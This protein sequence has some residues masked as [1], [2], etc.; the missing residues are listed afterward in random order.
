MKPLQG[1]IIKWK[2]IEKI[3]KSDHGLLGVSGAARELAQRAA[4]R[5]KSPGAEGMP[6]EITVIAS[7]PAEYQHET[8]FL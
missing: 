6:K 4:L 1:V 5:R 7:A 8:E 3:E 2:T